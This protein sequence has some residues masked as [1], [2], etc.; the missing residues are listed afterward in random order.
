MGLDWRLIVALL[1]SFI[2]KEN[3]IAVLGVLFGSAELTAGGGGGLA[4][5]LAATFP[6]STGLAFLTMQVL[7]IPCVATVAA[8]RQ[9]TG[10]WKWTLFNIVFL[11]VVSWAVGVA[12]FWLAR[13]VGL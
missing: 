1:A 10:S 8:V 12:V 5:T 7:F 9:E 6:I 11:L 13:L 3:T 2:A 4:Q